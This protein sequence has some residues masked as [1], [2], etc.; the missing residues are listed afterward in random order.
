LFEE[1]AKQNIHRRFKWEFFWPLLGFAAIPDWSRLDMKFR[2]MDRV[3]Q[4]VTEAE[5]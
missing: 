1:L 2:A 3:K 5:R 4:V